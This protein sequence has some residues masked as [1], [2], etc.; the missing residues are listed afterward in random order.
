MKPKKLLSQMSSD[1][2][3]DSVIALTTMKLERMTHGMPH[4]EFV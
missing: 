3:T 1:D 4:L 2:E